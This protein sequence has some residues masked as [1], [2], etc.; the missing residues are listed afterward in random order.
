LTCGFAGFPPEQRTRIKTTN[1]ITFQIFQTTQTTQTEQGTK[2][3]QLF[4]GQGK[5]NLEKSRCSDKK[6]PLYIYK[7]IIIFAL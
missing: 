4:S 5:F 7:K 2:N 6:V 1:L 3:C